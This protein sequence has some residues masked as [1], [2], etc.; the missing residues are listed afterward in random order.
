MFHH[1]KVVYSIYLRTK[2][3]PS[4]PIS[5]IPPQPWQPLVYSPHLWAFNFQN[6]LRQ[7]CHKWGT[8]S[9]GF[10]C[11][12]NILF[13]F[14]C[15]CAAGFTGP[16]C[17]LDINECQSN[18]CRNQA[19]CV[20]ELNSYSCKCQPGFSGS[21]CETGIYELSVINNNTKTNEIITMSHFTCAKHCP[22]TKNNAEYCVL[23]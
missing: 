12:N 17:E 6:L 4:S 1:F 7:C 8:S 23:T 9:N 21:R 3:N 16:Y 5:P 11:V 19:T 22:H 20:D 13:S 14:R 15:Q 2:Q 18:P 10:L